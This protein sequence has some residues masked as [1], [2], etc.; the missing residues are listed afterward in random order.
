MADPISL[1][2][3]DGS[4]RDYPA[5]T[6]AAA[7]LLLLAGLL[8]EEVG[9]LLE[10]VTDVVEGAGMD[11]PVGGELLEVGALPDLREVRDGGVGAL[12]DLAGAVRDDLHP[13]G[14][15]ADPAGVHPVRQAHADRRPSDCTWSAP[16]VIHTSS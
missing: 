1:I 8:L 3:P 16:V 15:L 11:A 10:L 9:E 4:V 5:G 14:D 13:A 6:T 7:G 2:F 12:A